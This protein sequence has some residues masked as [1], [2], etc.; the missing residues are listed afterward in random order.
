MKA[1]ERA[2]LS[3]T[4][5][6]GNTASRDVSAAGIVRDSWDGTLVLSPTHLLSSSVCWRLQKLLA[7]CGRIEQGR[8]TDWNQ[9]DTQAGITRVKA[10]ASEK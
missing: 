5:S 3:S 7:V 9:G 4:A 10:H 1:P 2:V 6:E 8:A